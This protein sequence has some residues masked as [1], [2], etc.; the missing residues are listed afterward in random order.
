MIY[1]S[2]PMSGIKHKNFPAFMKAALQLRKKGYQVINPAELDIG[3]PR[4]TWEACLRRDIR[5]EM[6]CKAIATLPNWKK[7]R[8]ARLEVYIARKLAWPIHSI[9]YYLKRRP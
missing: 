5:E 6:R 8:G 4:D 9:E 1:I 2:G 7:S 3:E